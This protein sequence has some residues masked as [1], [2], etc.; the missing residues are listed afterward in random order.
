MAFRTTPPPAFGATRTDPESPAS[1]RKADPDAPGGRHTTKGLRRRHATMPDACDALPELPAPGESMH[2]LLDHRWQMAP[3][4]A[5]ICRRGPNVAHLRLA[6][7]SVN[8]KHLNSLLS[9]CDG[10][11]V[12]RLTLV[13]SDYFERMDK[14]V[15]AVV[16][17][18]FAKRGFRVAY[19]ACHAKVSCFEFDDGT[20][21]TIEGSANLRGSRCFE[22]IAVANDRGLHDFHAGWIDTVIS[23]Y[24]VH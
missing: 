12:R 16:N 5:S 14:S 21:L 7:L 1:P 10:G 18:E 23:Q 20:T 13:L 4:I 22:Q 19:P 9:L 24:E 17:A 2:L 8:V 6:S 15:A 3:V 11:A